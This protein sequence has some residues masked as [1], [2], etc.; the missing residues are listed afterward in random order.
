MPNK[1]AI[2]SPS[3]KPIAPATTSLIGILLSCFS[4][5]AVKLLNLRIQNGDTSH[6]AI[7]PN[8]APIIMQI[9][10]ASV[11]LKMPV[12]I[13]KNSTVINSANNGLAN[14]KSAPPAITNVNVIKNFITLSTEFTSC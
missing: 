11:R 4:T 12:S 7:P 14:L 8:A 2:I 10:L 9:K 5:N 3:A 1:F 6:P 13:L